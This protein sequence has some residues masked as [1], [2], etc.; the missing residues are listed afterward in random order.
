MKKRTFLI[1]TVEIVAFWSISAVN[2]SLGSS[3]VGRER[4]ESIFGG[5]SWGW[6]FFWFVESLEFLQR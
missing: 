5:D 6:V 3:R 1:L 4:V 2:Y